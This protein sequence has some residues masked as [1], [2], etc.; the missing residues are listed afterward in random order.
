MT[1]SRTWVAA[2][3]LLLP[4]T[5]LACDD[6]NGSRASPSPT[7]PVDSTMSTTTV[8]VPF[9]TPPS[10]TGPGGVVSAAELARAQQV[11]LTFVDSLGKGDLVAAAATI[12]PI[13]EEHAAAAGGLQSLLQQ[14]TEGHGAWRSARERL[15]T[16]VGVERGVVVVVLEGTLAVE[17]TTEHRVAAF[18]VR[19]AESADAWFV[20]PWA[21]EI[22]ATRPLL[23]RSPAIDDEERAPIKAGEP[24]IMTV[25][26]AIAGSVWSVFDDHTPTKIDVTQGAHSS[27]ITGG[28]KEHVV[29]VFEAG[30]T[31]YATAFRPVDAA[32][33]PTPSSTLSRGQSPGVSVPF[34]SDSSNQLLRSCAAGDDA[35]CDAA[36]K[37]GVLDDGAFSFFHKQCDGGDQIYCVLF[38]QLVEAELR[39][40]ANGK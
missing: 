26:T 28:A 17:G 19:K 14:S 15:V 4:I 3:L 40:H 24:I 30:P 1:R 23:V 10:T 38:D 12:G 33:S 9:T 11:V 13:S 7:T 16:P 2:A 6:D 32:T 5:L 36:Q 31:I 8:V 29:V 39:I 37:P 22:A 21:Y 20:E 25:E 35:S 27:Q 34:L 18:P